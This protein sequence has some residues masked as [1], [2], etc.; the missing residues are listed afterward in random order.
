VVGS[1]PV[2]PQGGEIDGRAAV[3]NPFGNQLSRDGAELAAST[4]VRNTGERFSVA[5]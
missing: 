5:I 1:E 2:D 4:G 3:Q